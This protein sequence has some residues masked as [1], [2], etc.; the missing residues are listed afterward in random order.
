MEAIKVEIKALAIELRGLKYSIKDKQRKGESPCIL[1]VTYRKKAWRC[2]HLL[3]VYGMMR[4]L[5][6]VQIERPREGNE[7]DWSVVEEIRYASAT[8]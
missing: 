8:S 6:Y 7:P 4:G 2:R 5:K 1:Q 3:I